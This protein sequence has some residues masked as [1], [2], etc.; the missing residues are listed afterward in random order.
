MDKKYFILK[1]YVER[2]LVYYKI[3]DETPW[4]KISKKIWSA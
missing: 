1:E 3:F 4:S 2:E